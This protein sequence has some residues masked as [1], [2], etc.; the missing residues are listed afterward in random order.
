MKADKKN[1]YKQIFF[2]NVIAGL[3]W[4]VG[5]TFGFVLF[6]FILTFI[7]NQLGGLPIVGD[8]FASLIEV[9]QKALETRVGVGR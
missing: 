2:K 6:T 9:T 3:G 1:S 5:I 7:L 4:A 8:F